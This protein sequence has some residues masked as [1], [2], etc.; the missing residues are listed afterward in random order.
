MLLTRIVE[1]LPQRLE[2][3]LHFNHGGLVVFEG[4]GR[5]A[6]VPCIHA[7]VL[8]KRGMPTAAHNKPVARSARLSW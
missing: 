2:V 7:L 8:S 4:G 6:A 5:L 1:R 3:R